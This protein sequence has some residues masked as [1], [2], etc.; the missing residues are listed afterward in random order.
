MVKGGIYEA[1]MY[2]VGPSSLNESINMTQTEAL[3]SFDGRSE[4]IPH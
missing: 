2:F 3:G 4:I 1:A